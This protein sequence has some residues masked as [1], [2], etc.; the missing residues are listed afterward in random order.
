MFFDGT[1]N[2]FGHNNTNVIKARSIV[3]KKNQICF[4]TPG[5][6]SIADKNEHSTIGK[7][8]K[9]Y[10]GLG[11]GF[12][13]QEIVIEAYKF[14][15]NN[16]RKVDHI[17]LFGFSRGAYT[18]KVFAGLLHSC[19]LL[20][21]GNEYH[22]QYA[23]EL[24]SA[25]KYDQRLLNSF[26]KRFWSREVNIHYM[27]LWDSVS[28]VGN[29]LRMRNFPWTT[30]VQNV[31]IIR[32]ALAL[33]ERRALFQQNS[34]KSKGD[35]KEVW[36]A[37]VHGDVGGGVPEKESGLSKVPLKWILDEAESVGL[38]IDE[39]RYK[40]YVELE[41]KI[42]AAIDP[43]AEE[44]K[45][46]FLSFW[47]ILEF[48]PRYKITNYDPEERHY[49]WPRMQKRKIEGTQQEPCLVHNSVKKRAD[50]SKSGKMSSNIPKYY[51]I[52]D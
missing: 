11:L 12:G 26:K 9:K 32:H 4:Y 3:S 19:G 21:K 45:N 48:L 8:Y 36:F 10:L 22:I 37:G 23:Y 16:Y 5:V 27:G 1:S 25:K 52:I 20:E 17:Y 33:D 7:Y 30:N 44:H 43:Y 29:F 2:K 46:N 14:L 39:S 31:K 38:R 6:G 24:Y 51:K 41:D 47:L 13:L 28:S 50:K 49:Y 40:R 34:T 42:Y 18:A 35:I 15:M